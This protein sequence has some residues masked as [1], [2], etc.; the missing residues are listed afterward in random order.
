MLAISVSAAALVGAAPAFAQSAAPAAPTPAAPAP[1]ASGGTMVGE[2]VVTAERRSESLQSTP[3]AV[4]AFN[5]QALKTQRLDGGQ[6]LETSIPNVNYLARQL[7][8]L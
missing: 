2:I 3:V 5:A 7:R 1:S 6:N 4:S 8:R